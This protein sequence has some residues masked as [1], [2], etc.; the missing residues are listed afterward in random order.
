MLD[1]L[2]GAFGWVGEETRPCGFLGASVGGVATDIFP[3]GQYG[4]TG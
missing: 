1:F 2:F 4:S 3:H